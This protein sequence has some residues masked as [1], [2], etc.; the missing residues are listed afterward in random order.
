[1]EFKGLNITV[2]GLARSGVAAA[3]YLHDTGAEVTISDVKS[4][5]KL[6]QYIAQLNSPDIKLSLGADQVKD[7]EEADLVIL[8]PGIPANIPAC[9]KC[10]ELGI[11][12]ISEVELA[13]R[14]CQAPIIAITGSNGK[15]TTT[16]WTGEILK[17]IWKGSVQVAGNIGFPL[18]EAARNLD[19]N[20]IMVAELSSFQLETITSFKPRVAAILNI[21]QNHLDRYPSMD[22]YSNAKM[23]IFDYQSESDFAVLNLDNEELMHRLPEKIAA[24]KI[25]FSKNKEIQA[26]AFVQNGQIILRK[27]G[28]EYSVCKVNELSL[29]GP[30]NL[31][32]ALA[33]IAMIGC[34]E[35]N[36]K[37]MADPLQHFSG[38]EH[39]IEYIRELNGVKYYN[40]SKATTVVSVQTA[41]SALPSPIV[42]IMGGKDKGS[43]YRPLRPLL[44]EKVKHLIIIGQARDIIRRDLIDSCPLTLCDS[45]EEAVLLSQKLSCPG[46]SVLL[47]PA[48]SS[49][50]MFSD[51]EE[52]GRV[53]KKLVRGLV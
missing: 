31:E 5:D 40:D 51:Y 8:S 41:V 48:C 13:Y 20:G 47:S 1:M 37:E 21:S 32:N 27:D 6:Q 34:F 33:A 50:D 42:L 24:K 52:R 19:K 29:P 53:F 3:N 17:K 28:K 11:P 16:T 10:S 9:L 22:E 44:S 38:V 7:V 36:P 14:I 35:V 4:Q 25:Y 30:H 2:L 26:G 49:F 43:D 12:L 18:T 39:R 15:T 46:D 23:R 45:F